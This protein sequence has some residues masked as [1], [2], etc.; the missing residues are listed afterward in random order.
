[1]DWKSQVNRSLR[2]ASSASDTESRYS[3]PPL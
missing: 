1:M 3:D 2:R